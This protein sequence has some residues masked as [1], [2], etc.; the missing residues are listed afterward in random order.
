MGA[1][2]AMY[3]PQ[4][5]ETNSGRG[6]WTRL[7]DDL[8]DSTAF[9]CLS[10]ESKILY[11]YL[12]REHKGAYN[13]VKDTVILPYSQAAKKI[14]VGQATIRICIYE[15][16]QFGFIESSGGGGLLRVPNQYTFVAKWKYISEEEA[17][18]IKE[19]VKAYRKKYRQ[20]KSGSPP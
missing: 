3:E 10:P 14:G 1:K 9:T 4:F 17:Q 20:G 18:T 5:W 6:H 13:E 19:A 16:E 8:M 12:K 15:L 11:M 2:K 7:Y